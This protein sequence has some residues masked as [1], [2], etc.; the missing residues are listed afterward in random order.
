MRD[1][2]SP[3]RGLLLE[4]LN[5]GLA[6]VHG[7]ATVRDWL[8]GHRK[9]G[10]FHLI[11]LGKAAAA[12]TAGTLDGAGADLQS[13]LVVTRYGH[14][15]EPVYADPRL[16]CLEASHPLPDAQS[17]AAGNALQLFLERAPREAR[18]LFLI[19]GG[20]SSLVEVPVAGVTPDELRRLNRWLLGSGLP[21]ADIN[22]VRAAVSRIKGGRLA[23]QLHGRPAT[24]LLIS[25]VPGDVVGDIGSG[26]LI[27]SPSKALPKLPVEFAA[28]PF[29]VGAVRAA[30][31]VET[32]IIASN[33]HARAAAVQ[34]ARAR[35]LAAHDHGPLP[36]ADAQ[37]CGETL[38]REL[39]AAS[40]GIHVWGGESTVRL[41]PDAGAGGRNQ[42]LALAAA[43]VL[44]GQQDTFLLAAAT[45][46]SDGNDDAGALVDGTSLVRGRDAGYD[47]ELCLKRAASAGFLE[48]SGDLLH[49]GPTGTN[50]MDLIIGYRA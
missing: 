33:R 30:V 37:A 41:P 18:F 45:D 4:L 21:I 20:T 5:Q 43:R 40:P 24:Q 10:P 15:D 2:G 35:G 17:L 14:L 28:L 46:G 13:G 42:H 26:L 31:E 32:F 12:M 27:P 7:R 48:G 8:T 29:Q 49:T 38:A 34:A 47:A 23:A 11:A 16:M 3:P 25:D 1:T 6:A 19:S 22:R 50:V 39:M 44:A 9:P 36:V